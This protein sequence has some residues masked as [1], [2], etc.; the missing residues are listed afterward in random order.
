MKQP[1]TCAGC[2]SRFDVNP[3]VQRMLSSGQ[4]DRET[5]SLCWACARLHH[6][7]IQD[8]AVDA[9]FGWWPHN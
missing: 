4:G 1:F 8:L 9:K 5:P 2:G 6:S 7:A 3:R